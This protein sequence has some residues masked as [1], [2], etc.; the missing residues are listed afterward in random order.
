[1]NAVLEE[2]LKEPGFAKALEEAMDD[3]V[4]RDKGVQ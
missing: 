3:V 2:K 4:A 1:M